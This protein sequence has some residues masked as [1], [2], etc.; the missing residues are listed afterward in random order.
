MVPSLGTLGADLRFQTIDSLVSQSLTS[1]TLRG[2]MQW[3]TNSVV[4]RCP[5]GM[6]ILSLEKSCCI[7]ALSHVDRHRFICLSY[8]FPAQPCNLGHTDFI[9]CLRDSVTPGRRFPSWSRMAVRL[10]LFTLTGYSWSRKTPAPNA[11]PLE[12]WEMATVLAQVPVPH[13]DLDGEFN[14]VSRS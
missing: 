6:K 4:G 2:T 8:V 11:Y 1:I 10:M 13:P 5:G 7:T 12:E 3:L 14:I 9:L